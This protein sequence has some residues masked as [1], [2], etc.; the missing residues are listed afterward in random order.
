MIMWY[1]NLVS[2]LRKRIQKISATRALQDITDVYAENVCE[3]NGQHKYQGYPYLSNIYCEIS[4]A[5]MNGYIYIKAITDNGFEFREGLVKPIDPNKDSLG[6]SHEPYDRK[7][8]NET[9]EEAINKLRDV[10]CKYEKS[11]NN[12]NLIASDFEKALKEE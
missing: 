12:I 10:L 1:L 9:K 7:I 8:K 4:F 3:L 11:L 5:Y 6:G 2:Q